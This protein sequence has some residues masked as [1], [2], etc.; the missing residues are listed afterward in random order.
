MVKK[1]DRGNAPMLII[2]SVRLESL[3]K[4]KRV[5]AMRIVSRACKTNLSMESFWLWYCTDI[6]L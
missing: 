6:V 2:S 5:N 3:L 1:V 4:K